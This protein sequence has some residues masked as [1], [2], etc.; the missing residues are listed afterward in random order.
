MVVGVNDDQVSLG[1]A[2]QPPGVIELAFG[3]ARLVAQAQEELP[4]LVELLDAMRVGVGHVDIALPVQRNP[5]GRLELPVII[6]FCP[7]M[8]DA[9]VRSRDPHD[10][11]GFRALSVLRDRRDDIVV[12][13]AVGQVGMDVRRRAC[14]DQG[15]VLLG[16]PDLGLEPFHAEGVVLEPVEFLAFLGD[17]SGGLVVDVVEEGVGNRLPIERQL[18]IPDLDCDVARRPRQVGLLRCGSPARLRG[19]IDS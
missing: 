14:V 2:G 17:T 1:G 5:G 19:T 9:H 11:F 8:H 16:H 3:V 12:A 18:A 13:H 6:A 15:S 4:I 7:E 10:F